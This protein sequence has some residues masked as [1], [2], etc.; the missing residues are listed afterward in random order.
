[1]CNVV[2]R[3]LTLFDNYYVS[4]RKGDGG[5]DRFID[6]L[7]IK[8]YSELKTRLAI[9]LWGFSHQSKGNVLSGTAKK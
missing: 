7:A 3:L 5:G 8:N 2:K 6:M 1:M 4:Q 9:L